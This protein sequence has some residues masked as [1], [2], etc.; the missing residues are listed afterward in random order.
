MKRSFNTLCGNQETTTTISSGI[1][2]LF[3]TELWILIITAATDHDS[4]FS[5]LCLSPGTTLFIRHHAVLEKVP[6]LRFYFANHYKAPPR[7]ELELNGS[8]LISLQPT[9]IKMTRK[10]Y[11]DCATLL[12]LAPSLTAL[13]C[14]CCNWT[15]HPMIQM[16]DSEEEG[17]SPS[18]FDVDD[19]IGTPEALTLENVL[20]SLTNLR[21]L[22]LDC[23]DYFDTAAVYAA[24]VPLTRLESLHM[25]D[26]CKQESLPGSMGIL[27]NMTR[28]HSLSIYST[29]GYVEPSQI[30]HLTGLTRVRLDPPPEVINP[31]DIASYWSH[32]TSLSNL[33]E[34]YVDAP[35]NRDTREPVLDDA[36]LA[37]VEASQQGG[38]VPITLV[39]HNDMP[40]FLQDRMGTRGDYYWSVG[41]DSGED[42]SSGEKSGDDSISISMSSLSEEEEEEEEEESDIGDDSVE[43]EDSDDVL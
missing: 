30:T 25:E 20:G 15:R 32:L 37:L 9:T 24:L 43:K 8:R 22:V 19:G 41:S 23:N 5:W 29:D 18:D 11:V 17:E 42:S 1:S 33:R 21:H 39:P 13:D 7:K 4:I 14:H 3:P 27:D 38:G 40:R 34:L 31:D 2:T 16:A 10:R 28:L 12:Q 26:L 6:L 36:L 35:V